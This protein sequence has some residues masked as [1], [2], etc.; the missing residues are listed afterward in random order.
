MTIDQLTFPF[1]FFFIHQ[2]VVIGKSLEL[3]SGNMKYFMPD[4]ILFFFADTDYTDY[5]V[6]YICG[7]YSLGA[8][9]DIPNTLS[10]EAQSSTTKAP[11]PNMFILM[12]RDKSKN[13]T[14]YDMEGIK[15]TIRNKYGCYFNMAHPTAQDDATCK[16][17]N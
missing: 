17:V 3:N 8:G 2:Y 14:K 16:S 9:A 12:T 7:N 11:P 5:A 15:K 10:T 1:P 13:T 4:V 6:V